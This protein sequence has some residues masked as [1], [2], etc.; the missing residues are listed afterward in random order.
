MTDIKLSICIPTYNRAPYLRTALECL[1]EARFDFTHEIVISDNASSDDT[2]EVVQSF[3]DLGLPI[4]FLRCPVNAGGG[5][6]L[7]NAI[8]HARGEYMVYQGDDD[9]LILDQLAV[10]VGYLDANPDV[11][12]CQAPWSLY[13]EVDDRDL[14]LFYHLDGEMRFERHDFLGIFEL[15]MERHV[16][17]EIAV[18]RM[19][20]V[21]SAIVPRFF[22]FWPFVYLA[23]FIDQ[24]AVAFLTEPFYRS[25]TVSKIAPSREQAGFIDVMTSW[26]MYRGGLEYFLHVAAQRGMLNTSDDV[27]ALYDRLCKIFTMV[28]MSVAIRFWIA[29]HDWIRAYELFTR[30]S[31]GGLGDYPGVGELRSQFPTMVGLQTLAFKVG[32]IPEIGYLVCDTDDTTSLAEV[33]RNLGLPD[34]VKI[35]SSSNCDPAVADKSAVL[36]T[37]VEQED[38]FVTRGYNRNFIFQDADL[39]RYVLV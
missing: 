18:Y 12:V 9:L 8:H 32:A 22:C 19:S 28:R 20:A 5:P 11:T 25:V 23:H 34:T 1:A 15:M 36:V 35:V 26:D 39:T 16:F 7:T 10:V 4:N 37:S 38:D 13:D 14:G 21:R 17:P 2:A 3:I 6:N 29:R 33:L 24:G 30:M 31:L 27:L